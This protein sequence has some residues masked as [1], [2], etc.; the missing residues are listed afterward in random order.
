[1]QH[2]AEA[3]CALDVLEHLPFQLGILEKAIIG[4]FRRRNLSR[5]K[6]NLKSYEKDK[7][8]GNI[9]KMVMN[10]LSF[11]GYYINSPFG[12]TGA[13]NLPQDRHDPERS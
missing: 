12:L 10:M 3:P 7:P 5:Q 1:M 11:P 9:I 2:L 4:W 13:S 6:D 8:A